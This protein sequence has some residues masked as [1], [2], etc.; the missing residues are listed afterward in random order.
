[1]I[2]DTSTVSFTTAVNPYSVFVQGGCVAGWGGQCCLSHCGREPCCLR[3]SPARACS[4]APP[5]AALCA[6]HRSKDADSKKKVAA[7]IARKKQHYLRPATYYLL[8]TT[9]YLHLLPTTYDLLS[10]TYDL[11]HTTYYLRPTTY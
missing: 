6:V 10:T 11:R 4:E 5:S 2:I 1:M 3:R 8:P 7:L 9:Y